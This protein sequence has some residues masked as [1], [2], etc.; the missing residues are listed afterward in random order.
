M[1][2]VAIARFMPRTRVAGTPI[3]TPST[4][5]SS[6]ASS[7]ANGNGTCPFARWMTA[8]PATPAKASGAS[9]ICPT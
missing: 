4:V 3:T 6:A 8:K 1:A 7:T 9:E 5:A 2:S